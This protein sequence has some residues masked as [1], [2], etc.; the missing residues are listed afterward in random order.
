M[1]VN[2]CRSIESCLGG[3]KTRASLMPWDQHGG[4]LLIGHVVSGV[5]EA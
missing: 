1:Q 5:Q 4:N 2:L 3:I